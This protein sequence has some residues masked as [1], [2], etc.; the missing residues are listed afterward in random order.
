MSGRIALTQWA[1]QVGCGQLLLRH[2]VNGLSIGSDQAEPLQAECDAL[3]RTLST[4]R[5]VLGAGYGNTERL[6]S[7][8]KSMRVPFLSQW[9]VTELDVREAL[10]KGQYDNAR[11]ARRRGGRGQ[12]AADAPRLVVA[13]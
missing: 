10:A 9:E 6:V 5:N 1:I 11:D 12:G 4:T 13:L 7:A 3:G 2:L 8:Y